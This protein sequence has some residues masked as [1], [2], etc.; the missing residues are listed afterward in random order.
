[1]SA[2]EVVQKPCFIPTMAEEITA[3][4]TFTRKCYLAEEENERKR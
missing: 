4:I 1:M 2:I 3:R